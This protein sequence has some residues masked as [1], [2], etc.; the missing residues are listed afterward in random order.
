MA[1][2]K[3]R[4]QSRVEGGRRR[5]GAGCIKQIE[6][7]VAREAARHSVSK[8]FVISVILAKAFN[9]KEQEEY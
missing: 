7:A 4:F 1:K 5:I 6:A 3:I 2:P 8:S 9:I